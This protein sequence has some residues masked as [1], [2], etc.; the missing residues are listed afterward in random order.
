MEKPQNDKRDE[1]DEAPDSAEG[2][3]PETPARKVVVTPLDEDKNLEKGIEVSE[4]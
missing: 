3:K 2:R 4:T 1:H